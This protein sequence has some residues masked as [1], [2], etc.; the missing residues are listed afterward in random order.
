ME[1][2]IPLF[3][4]AVVLYAVIFFRKLFIQFYYVFKFILAYIKSIQKDL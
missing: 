3:L 2:L 1:I 4:S